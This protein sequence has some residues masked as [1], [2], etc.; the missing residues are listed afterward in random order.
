M[1]EDGVVGCVESLS[2]VS[3][4]V[5]GVPKAF[6]AGGASVLELGLCRGV[7][8]DSRGEATGSSREGN[9]TGALGD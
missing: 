7:C 3:Y 1:A 5:A 8:G 9:S 4:D 2:E 6:D